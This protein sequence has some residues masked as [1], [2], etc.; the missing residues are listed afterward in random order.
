MIRII[1]KTGE[2]C[3][4]RSL[5]YNEGM[6]K[7]TFYTKQKCSLCDQAYEM[8]MQLINDIPMEINVIDITHPHNRQGGKYDERIPV[9]TTP[10][11]D[12]E[13]GWPFTHEDL[14]RYLSQ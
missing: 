12:T 1:F 7:V 11:S 5:L 10:N 13:L 8:L 3:Y 14:R 4:L 2:S 9:I 6:K